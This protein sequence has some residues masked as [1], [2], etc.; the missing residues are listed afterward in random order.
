MPAQVC[1]VENQLFTSS[2][3]SSL[4]GS[5]ADPTATF[6][7]LVD[8]L[9]NIVNGTA[10]KDAV[11]WSRHLKPEIVQGNGAGAI[12]YT[13]GF[14]QQDDA[15]TSRTITVCIPSI[16]IIDFTAYISAV[17]ASPNN[18]TVYA[19]VNG[20]IVSDITLDTNVPSFAED[21]SITS[22][23]QVRV[24]VGAGT[25]T[26]MMGGYAFNNTGSFSRLSFVAWAVAQ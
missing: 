4:C 17:G 9:E 22:S 10:I 23:R 2:Y 12:N 24:P 5:P 8:D 3:L 1:P 14:A 13:G 26:I 20:S 18:M 15:S 21:I 11:I 6:Q 16:L 7:K 25:H 19:K